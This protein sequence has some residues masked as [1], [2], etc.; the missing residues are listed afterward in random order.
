MIPFESLLKDMRPCACLAEI[1]S[2]GWQ[3]EKEAIC[4][5]QEAGWERSGDKGDAEDGGPGAG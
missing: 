4:V 1:D 3:D 2:G 5:K